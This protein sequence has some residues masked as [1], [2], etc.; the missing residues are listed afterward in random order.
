MQQADKIILHSLF[1]SRMVQILF[2]MPWLLKKSYW[3]IWGGDLYIYQIEQ[4]D[5]KWK[6]QEFFRRPVIKNMG[7]LVTYIEGD[8]DLVRK[9]YKAKGKY[10]ECLMY[11]SN[12]YKDYQ[13]PNKKTN[14]VNIQIGNSANPSN[15][16]I[17]VLEKLSAYKDMDINIFA[18]LSYGNQEHAQKVID[19]GK[20]IFGNKFKPLVNFMTFDTY[21]KFLND[22][23]I[24]IFNHKRQQAMGNTITLLGLGKRVYIRSDTTQWH[25]FNN[26]NIK[27][28]DTEDLEKINLMNIE[29]N[30]HNTYTI[31]DYF[32]IKNLKSQL[33]EI[34]L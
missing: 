16:H 24:A 20:E 31:G 30:A 14:T 25:F 15:N 13:M 9:W 26:I 17:E 2:F 28:Y 33:K 23:D 34:F 11:S 18:P 7:N 27:V 8:I 6:I 12:L 5:W 29:N 3:V 10:H 32:S 1:D 19:K 22:I 21:L 4:R